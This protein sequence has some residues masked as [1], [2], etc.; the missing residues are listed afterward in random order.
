[1]Y[2]VFHPPSFIHFSP[3]GRLSTLRFHLTPPS[4]NTNMTPPDKPTL[5]LSPVVLLVLQDPGRE[6]DRG[7]AQERRRAHGHAALGGPVSKRQAHRRSRSRSRAVSAIGECTL[8]SWFSQ[9]ISPARVFLRNGGVSAS[10]RV[11]GGCN[12]VDSSFPWAAKRLRSKMLGRSIMTT[13]VPCF[14]VPRHF[15]D[16][17]GAQ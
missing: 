13:L 15:F 2:C 10:P 16:C 17:W 7:R 9:L 4:E 1:M 6:G 5:Q 11:G 12:R 3:W 14:C 8:T